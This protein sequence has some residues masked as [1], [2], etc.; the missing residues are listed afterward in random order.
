MS[1]FFD[2]KSQLFAL[3]GN[4]D[5]C[6]RFQILFQDEIGNRFADMFL[7]NPAQGARP[8]FRVVILS[9]Q[10]RFGPVRQLQMQILSGQ[11]LLFFLLAVD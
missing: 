6:P 8:P 9:Q 5:R 10:P 3:D 2:H 1:L 11:Q 4:F 7:N